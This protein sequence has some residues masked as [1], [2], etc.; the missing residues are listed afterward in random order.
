MKK[1][2][3]LIAAMAIAGGANAA[4]IAYWN[5]NDLSIATASA[6]GA[7][8]VPTSINASQGTGTL[9]LSSW[10]G[11]VDDFT[12]S[13]INVRGSDP[14]EESLSLISNAG[15][16]TYIQISFSMTGFTSLDVTFATRGTSTGF[17]TGQWSWSTDGSSF[18][19]FGPN[20]AT[21]STTFALAPTVSTT[22]LDDAA[23][24]YL[25]YTLNGAS[26][27]TG[28]NRIENLQ[29]RAIPEPGTLGVLMAAGAALAIR[30]RR[31]SE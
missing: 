2:I 30:R 23:T 10:G 26:S 29:L 18:T 6:P 28:N 16:G 17:S 20:T 24:A 4:L 12:G 5:F 21:T 15:N 9:D 11:T 25:R 7:G 13:T 22:A 19:D 27:T 1:A 3:V 14:A 8:G 31:R